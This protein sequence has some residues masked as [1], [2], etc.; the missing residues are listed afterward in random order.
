ML[1]GRAFDLV[2]ARKVGDGPTLATVWTTDGKLSG[3]H[4]LAMW[5]CTSFLMYQFTAVRAL[6]TVSFSYQRE[7][8]P[9][10][11]EQKPN[12]KCTPALAFSCADNAGNHA[13]YYPDNY[14]LH[15][16]NF[17]PNDI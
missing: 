1:A 12:H 11:P 17:S 13:A 14:V 15:G 10:W 2:V 7:H 4:P 3:N 9:Q 16:G 6:S 8:D 5:A